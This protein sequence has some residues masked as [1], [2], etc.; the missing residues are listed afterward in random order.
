M[1]KDKMYR[2]NFSRTVGS[3]YHTN[4]RVTFTGDVE[5]EVLS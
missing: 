4:Q 1:M 5:I 3:G 2:L